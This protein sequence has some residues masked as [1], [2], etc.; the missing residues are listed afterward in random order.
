M[1][2]GGFMKCLL[3]MILISFYFG[4]SQAS[5]PS[6]KKQSALLWGAGSIHGGVAGRGFSLLNLKNFPGKNGNIERL[7]I[8]IGDNKMQKLSGIPGY[9]H[10][11]NKPDFK[12]VVIHF[13]QMTMAKQ[14]LSDLKK[15]FAKSPFV[16]NV[17]LIVD[18]STQTTSL[19]LDLHKR[20]SVRALPQVGTKERAAMINID[21]FDEKLL[22]K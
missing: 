5:I 8:E 12:S 14:P 17:D 11:E 15:Q 18:S 7:V 22:K 10:I 20:T 3:L 2:Q 6:A 4:E 19:I 21:L 9:F 13:Q 1:R 16:K